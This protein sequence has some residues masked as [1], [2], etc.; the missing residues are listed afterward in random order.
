MSRRKTTVSEKE[1]VAESVEMFLGGIMKLF[2]ALIAVL[3]LVVMPFYFQE[4]YSHIGSDKSYFFRTGALK[5]GKL[6]IPAFV[7]WIMF[8]GAADIVRYGR[9]KRSG[10]S[11]PEMT[12]WAYLRDVWKK[13]FTMSDV[14]AVCFAISV[15]ISYLCTDYRKT[16]LW[17][18]KGWYMGMIPQLTLILIYFVLSG[19]EWKKAA[20]W[21][22]FIALMASA[23]TYVLAYLNR[24]D[25]W[26]LPMAN[27]GLPLYISTIGNINWFCAYAVVLTFVGAGIFFADDGKYKWRTALLAL[28]VFV[29]FLAV[30]TQGSESGIFS[31]TGIFLTLYLLT[32]YS[33]GGEDVKR[34][35]L[36]RFWQLALILGC[37]GAF[38][39]ILRMI[40]PGRMNL[41]AKLGGLIYSPLAVVIIAVAAAGWYLTVRWSGSVKLLRKSANVLWVSVLAAL[42]VYVALVAVNTARPGSLGALSHKRAFTFNNKWGSSRGAT[43]TLGLRSFLEL[44]GLHK[45]TGAG[46]DCMADFLYSEKSPELTAAARK[47]FENKRLTNA[48]CEVLTILVNMGALGA[49]TYIG[50]FVTVIRKMLSSKNGYAFACGLGVLAYTLNNLWSFQ[51]SMGVAAVFAVMGLGMYFVRTE[52]SE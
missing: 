45:L 41:T 46:P 47:A 21:M 30:T 16:A 4:G 6:L 32:A 36:C 1:G 44:D 37:A 52:R 48:H 26:P 39:W 50:L 5:V 19:F 24:F 27:S 43:W 22:T 15:V 8:R 14:F 3:I 2:S 38:T 51:Q 35:R 49:L 9:S 12:L 11:A 25:I 29:A 40:F 28:Y 10:R 13:S 33:Q 18:T 31:V 23:V 17:G 20:E 34:V 7:A 42:V